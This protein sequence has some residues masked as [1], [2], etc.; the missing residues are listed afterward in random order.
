MTYYLQV[1]VEKTSTRTDVQVHQ[2]EL[3]TS[4][5]SCCIVKQCNNVYLGCV[6]LPIYVFKQ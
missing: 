4:A 3:V 6:I 2:N 1:H 5:I